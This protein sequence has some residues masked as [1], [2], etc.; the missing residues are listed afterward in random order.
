MPNNNI[1][2]IIIAIGSGGA[3]IVLLFTLFFII[4]RLM[5]GG[6][7][8]ILTE[9]GNEKQRD[10]RHKLWEESFDEKTDYNDQKYVYLGEICV[11]LDRI[12]VLAY[13][14]IINRKLL[15]NFFGETVQKCWERLEAYLIHENKKDIH[16]IDFKKGKKN[17]KLGAHC[18]YFRWLNE[19]C[20]KFKPK[21]KK[22]L[23][24]GPYEIKEE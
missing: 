9:V 17:M 3:F 2:Q 15:I 5:L 21:K 1:M 22:N 18:R 10:N 20:K 16:Q 19:E 23:F 14:R 4:K 6:L 7:S 24:F 11:A 12:G 13:Y 8:H